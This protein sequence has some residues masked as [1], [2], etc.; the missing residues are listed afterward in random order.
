MRGKWK[1]NGRWNYANGKIYVITDGKRVY[2]GSTV[3][4]N[5]SRCLWYLH[6]RY[7]KYKAKT[8]LQ[9]HPAFFVFESNR[10]HFI[11]ILERYP[12]HSQPE[13]NDREDYWKGKCSIEI[14]SRLGLTPF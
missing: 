6:T 5:V 12:C 7:K 13:L 9:Y 2:V 4:K 11:T 10:P 1:E 3:I 14:L 8:N